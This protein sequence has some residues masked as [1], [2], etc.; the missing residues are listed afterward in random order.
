[1][2]KFDPW[3]G[4]RY[5]DEGLD[6]VRLLVLGESHYG[7]P[8]CEVSHYTSELVQLWGQQKRH[9]FY[10]SVQRLVV[11][12]R[13]WL[14]DAERRNFW[15]RVAFYNYVQSLVGERPRDRPT[16]EMWLAACEPLLQTLAELK[17]HALLVLGW[18]LHQHLPELPATLAVCAVPH[19][20][21]PGFR[22]T[23]WQ[24]AVRNALFPRTEPV[25]QTNTD[26]R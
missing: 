18:T 11:G 26:T 25:A 13:G 5:Q 6:G 9:R 17:P 23:A 2:R 8:T 21:S 22:Y 12:G 16:P 10:S 7:P 14:S 19:P 20:S 1:M 24:S 3:I 4:C 15:D